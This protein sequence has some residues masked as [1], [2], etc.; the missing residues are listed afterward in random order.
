MRDQSSLDS[1][2]VEIYMRGLLGSVCRNMLLL[3]WLLL[4]TQGRCWTLLSMLL[5]RLQM[6]KLLVVAVDLL[7]LQL[8]LLMLIWRQIMALDIICI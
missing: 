4:V 5:D 3:I 1:R 7:I 6:T 8:L 2:R